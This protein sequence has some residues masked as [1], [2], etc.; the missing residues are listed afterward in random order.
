M[1]YERVSD[2]LFNNV[3]DNW[4]I[5]G[6]GDCYERLASVIEMICNLASNL[7]KANAKGIMFSLSLP[8]PWNGLSRGD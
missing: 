1:S 5:F 3:L 6:E 7:C 2:H 8:Q 4:V